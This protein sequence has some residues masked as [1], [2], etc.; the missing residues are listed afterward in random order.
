MGRVDHLD[1]GGEDARAQSILSLEHSGEALSLV[2]AGRAKVDGASHVRGA[3][4]VKV[5]QFNL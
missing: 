5:K 3:V 4:P 2:Q 1:F